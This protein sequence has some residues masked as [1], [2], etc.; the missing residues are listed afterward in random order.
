MKNGKCSKRFPKKFS[1][2]TKIDEEDFLHYRR[3]YDGRTIKKKSTELDNHCIVP[4]NPKLLLKYQAHINVEYTCQT[5]AIKYLFKYI[6]KG[7]DRVIAVFSHSAPDS[8]KSRTIDES[9]STIIVGMYQ[10]VKLLGGFLVLKFIID[11]L[12]FKDLTMS[13][14]EIKSNALAK[15]EK[16][17][18]SNGRSLRDYADMPFP[19]GGLLSEVH[20]KLILD[21][22]SYD[23]AS[24]TELYK[25]N[26]DVGKD[27]DGEATIE[28]PDEIL[29]KD[30]ETGLAKLVEFVYPNFLESSTDP[31]F[32]QECA[33]LSPT[34]TN[35]AMINEYLMSFI[36]E[37]K[38]IYLSSTT[39]CK[40]DANFKNEQDTYSHDILNTFIA[41]GLP[42]HKL[43][44]KVGLPVMLLKYIDQSNGLCNGTRLLITILGN[45]IIEAKILSGNNID[46]IVLIPRITMMPSS[47]TFPIKFKRGQFPVV[48]CF[49]MTINKSQGQTLSDVG[50]HLPMP[51]FSH[52]QLY[53]A[54]ERVKSKQDF[55]AGC[56]RLK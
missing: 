3:G 25:Q 49:A 36:P 56:A 20:T 16:I 14:E 15:A 54:L 22:L 1:T 38:R 32:F 51:V 19:S 42:N 52:V 27:F 10:H 9:K 33:I 31:N 53:M 11:V 34:L 24:F 13:D 46:Q 47:H 12:L 29:I 7:N 43:N 37:D 48:R 17:L 6:H 8:D 50:I 35:I 39:I 2:R 4:Y 40:E 45:H 44:F 30:Q 28:V 26:G 41:S 55:E 18:H 21:E 5:N 23:R